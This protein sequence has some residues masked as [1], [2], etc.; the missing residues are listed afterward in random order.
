[1]AVEDEGPKFG[2]GR[3]ERLV[4][5]ALSLKPAR[6]WQACARVLRA[7]CSGFRVGACLTAT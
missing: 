1:V 2:G 7:G 5:H 3:R 4:R 6:I